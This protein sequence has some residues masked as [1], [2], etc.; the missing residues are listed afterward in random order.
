MVREYANGHV[1]A[2]PTPIH[3]LQSIME[4]GVGSNEIA[5]VIGMHVNFTTTTNM[6][7]SIDDGYTMI[8]AIIN[9][10][11]GHEVFVT[12]YN[13]TVVNGITVNTTMEYFD[14]LTGEYN[15]TTNSTAITH[16]R[17]ITGLK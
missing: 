12:G 7:Q 13:T 4:N 17:V 10:T 5:D 14:P 1:P 3:T 16:V 2:G 15:E 11:G 9:G 6:Y 8:G